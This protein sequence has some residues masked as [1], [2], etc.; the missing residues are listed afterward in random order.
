MTLT[1]NSPLII[2]ALVV[3]I[4]ELAGCVLWL[5]RRMRRVQAHRDDL[6]VHADMQG[7]A[8][9]EALNEIDRYRRLPR[10]GA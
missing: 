6:I 2:G 10:R 5:W 8:L 9:R 4:A 3:V 7:D 1:I